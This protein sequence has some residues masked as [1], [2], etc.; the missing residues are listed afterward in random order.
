MVAHE[1]WRRIAVVPACILVVAALS[2]GSV[3]RPG[4]D[5]T[6]GPSDGSF[7]VAVR[8]AR[9]Q[10]IPLSALPLS[11]APGSV[12]HSV[13]TGGAK[14][15]AFGFDDGPWPYTTTA[16]MSAF[17][18][19]GARA[20]FFMIGVHLLK[21]PDIGRSVAARGHEIGNHT[22]THPYTAKTILPQIV[23]AAQL[24]ASVTGVTPRL[25]RA[26]GLLSNA[27]LQNGLATLGYCNIFASIFTGDAATWRPSAATICGRFKAGLR[28]GA[29]VLAHDGGGRHETTAAAVP[30]ML[31]AAIR[32]GYRIVTISELL[33]S[34][35][36]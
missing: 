28:P 13:D 6:P 36:P 1:R 31:D 34:A 3:V 12:V 15:V 21:Y 24:I 27:E 7:S 23:P 9:S 14:L 2:A 18:Q 20:T 4:T 26:P 10:V 5:P 16:I 25:F 19:R 33:A 32:S 30:C 29:I 35:A 11:C 17:E 22:V 8:G